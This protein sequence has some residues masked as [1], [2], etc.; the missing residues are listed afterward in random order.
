MTVSPR[1]IRRFSLAALLA[2]LLLLAGMFAD[3]QLRRRP[4]VTEVDL[5]QVAASSDET[6]V[7][8]H[9][10]FEYSDTL[11]IE[12]N[13]RVAASET[14]EFASG[15]YELRDVEVS[16]F[17][18]GQVAYGLISRQARFNPGRRE[19]LV[20]G[21]AQLSL[22]GGIAARAD[23]F[24]LRGPERNLESSGVVTF[25]GPGWA[26]VAGGLSGHLADNVIDIVGGLSASAR[27]GPGEPAL[28]L[29][30]PAARY[31]RSVAHLEFAEGLTLLKGGL[32]VG[33]RRAAIQLDQAEGTVR[34]LELA[35]GVTAEGSFA[36]GEQL[37]LDSDSAI[38]EAAA[39]GRLRL[40]AQPAA[41]GWVS[42][43]WRDLGGTWRE[44]TAWRVLGE[45]TASSWEWLEGQE[46]ACAAEATPGG[47]LRTLSARALRVGFGDRVA[48]S[49]EGTGAV[50]IAEA[51]TW[52][53]G[54]SLSSTLADRRFVLTGIGGSRVTMGTREATCVGDRIEGGGDGALMATGE[55]VGQLD[56]ST[57]LGDSG[58]PVRFAAESARWQAN[59]IT[60]EGQ[61]RLWQG[62]RLLRADTLDYDREAEVVTGIGHVLTVGRLE[63]G[64]STGADV[65]VQSRTLAYDR[66][67]GRAAWE[68]EV[69]AKDARATSR[70]QR[71]VATLSASGAIKAADLE[72]G[73]T[74]LEA[75]SG[76]ELRGERARLRAE[77]DVLEVWGQPVVVREPSG[78]QVKGER[79][80]WDR[81]SGTILVVGEPG[82]PS[83]TLYHPETKGGGK[84][85]RRSP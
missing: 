53:E 31:R 13:F 20:S 4:I 71:L 33:A 63:Q 62:P 18:R 66:Q 36:G 12:P 19:A 69:T 7:R 64:A 45:G 11:G 42:A 50:R 55:V 47:P 43:S 81:R 70:C 85:P 57:A 78:N 84:P 58:V 35:G 51:A 79:L 67:G 74:I 41:S 48:R 37:S 68:G 39:D 56:R 1:S 34:R 61:A 60:L 27:Q 21:E 15:W 23:G 77:D 3:R 14:V 72:G 29:L 83:E 54:E 40:T 24:V 10:G 49:V 8:V 17:H 25:A 26:G 30:A 52:A 22:G 76:R 32:Q 6:A 65:E 5:G 44:L 2:W 38:I 82:S 59:R 73:V 75:D 9:R 28:V 46:L 80:S 16:L